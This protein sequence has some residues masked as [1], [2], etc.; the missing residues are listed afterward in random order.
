MKNCFKCHE[1]KELSEFYRHR[2]MAGGHL[3]KCKS[4]TR[5]DV[6]EYRKQNLDRVKEYD[7]I[8][9]R[10]EKHSERN[11]LSYLKRTA[12]PEG[13]EAEWSYKRTWKEKN[14]DKRAAHVLVG[15]AIKAGKLMPQPCERCCNTHDIHA[16]H[17]DYSKPL[18]VTWLC[19]KCH[20]ERHREINAERRV[21]I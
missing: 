14:R 8:R 11:R 21:N 4:C 17:E 2:G 20:G 6:G 10:S 16:H 15:N 3:N 19:T 5:A 18:A 1:E 13:K 12:T 9:G 7:R